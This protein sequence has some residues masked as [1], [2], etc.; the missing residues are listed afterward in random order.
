MAMTAA[1]MPRER[2]D[3]APQATIMNEGRRLCHSS[4]TECTVGLRKIRMLRTQFRSAV[5]DMNHVA[6]PSE[7]R[8]PLD[9]RDDISRRLSG[10]GEAGTHGPC[11]T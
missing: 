1:D 7:T 2:Q 8:R 10:L 11:S 3:A 4:C 5:R 9:Y 6:L